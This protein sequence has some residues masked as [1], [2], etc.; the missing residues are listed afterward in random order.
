MN[1]SGKLALHAATL[2]QRIVA[3]VGTGDHTVVGDLMFLCAWD[4]GL[5]PWLSGALRVRQISRANPIIAAWDGADSS[6]LP[7]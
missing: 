5:V 4:A 2:A 3:R 1:V 6:G 7:S